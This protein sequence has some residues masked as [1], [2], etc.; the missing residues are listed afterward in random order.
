MQK[1]DV[2]PALDFRTAAL[3][4]VAVGTTIYTFYRL[5]QVLQLW[6]KVRQSQAW[7]SAGGTVLKSRVSRSTI[8]MKGRNV[9]RYTPLVDYEYSV[10]GKQ[11]K[12]KEIMFGWAPAYSSEGRALAY[13][14]RYPVGS[15]VTLFYNPSKPR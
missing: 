2:M 5:F 8:F 9:T 12:G 14:D 1:G 10:N 13:V 6:Q 11:Y 7:P 15:Q 3:A 4:V